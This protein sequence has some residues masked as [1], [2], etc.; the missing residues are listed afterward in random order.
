[1]RSKLVVAVLHEVFCVG[2]TGFLSGTEIQFAGCTADGS[3]VLDLVTRCEPDV[4]LLSLQLLQDDGM[5]VLQRVK[6]SRPQ[7]PVIMVA[8]Y[9]HP[10]HLAQAHA[11]GAAGFLL[12]NFS[13]AKLLETIR[14][15]AAGK[16][17]WTREDMRR[18]TGVMTTPRFDANIDVPLTPREAEVLRQ[19]T[20][21]HTNRRIAEGLGI[22]YETVK[23]HVQHSLT[24]LGVEDRTQAAVWAGRHG[25][26]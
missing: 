23:E 11:L 16:R 14:A 15:A 7:I 5:R 6:E 9:D 2:L 19:M 13:R 4:L 24:K 1:M 18:V 12:K 10:A 26:A 20:L 3:Q 17:V 25:L 22:S 8:C 21:G